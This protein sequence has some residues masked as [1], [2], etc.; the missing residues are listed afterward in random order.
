[1]LKRKRETRLKDRRSH[2]KTEYVKVIW[3][4]DSVSEEYESVTAFSEKFNKRIIVILANNVN[5]EI[6]LSRFESVGIKQVIDN[7]DNI[8]Y[9]V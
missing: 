1:M 4:D 2:F 7:K 9:P 8:L 6:P 3:K 5:Y